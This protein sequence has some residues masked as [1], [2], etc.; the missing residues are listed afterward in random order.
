[1][2]NVSAYIYF[3]VKFYKVMLFK[4]KL[5]KVMLLKEKLYKV[6]L[7]KVIQSGGIL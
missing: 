4:E 2:Q 1:M 6:K 5:H 7:F 3:N